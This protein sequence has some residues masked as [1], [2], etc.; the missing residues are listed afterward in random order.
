MTPLSS[1]VTYYL[2]KTWHPA[3]IEPCPVS[4]TCAPYILVG[5][6]TSCNN[7][8][9]IRCLCNSLLVQEKNM[10]T[11][12]ALITSIETHFLFV[13]LITNSAKEAQQISSIFA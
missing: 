2:S 13:L 1:T 8:P 6:I 7:R 5:L 3:R 10:V 12:T 11:Y 4:A 9:F